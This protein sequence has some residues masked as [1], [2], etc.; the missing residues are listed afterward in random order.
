MPPGI[1]V[2]LSPGGMF[3]RSSPFPEWG[4]KLPPQFSA[5]FYGQ[6]AGCIKTP[7]GTEVGL[8]PGTLC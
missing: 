7:L 2:G 1:E 6:T 3:M 4:R 8:S 5:H